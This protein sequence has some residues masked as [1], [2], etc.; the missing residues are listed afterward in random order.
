MKSVDSKISIVL[1]TYNGARYLRRSMES[2]LTQTYHN[3]ELIVVDDCSTDKT[4]E[5]VH[6]FEDRRIRYI[7]NVQNQRL[8]RSLNAGFQAATGDYLTWTSDDNFYMP[9]ALEKM[10]QC[11]QDKNGDFVYTDILAVLNDDIDEA[12]YEP[13]GDSNELDKHNCIRAC[14]LYTRKVLETVGPYDP[15]MELIEDY[16]YW[17][18]VSKHFPMLHIKEPLYYYRYHPQQ[19]YT[20]RWNEI[21]IIEFLFKVK[22]GFKSMDEVNWFMRDGVANRFVSR[23]VHKPRIKKILGRYKAGELSFTETRTMIHGL[24]NG[25]KS[26][27]RRLEG[28]VS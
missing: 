3:I 6:Q 19:L 4:A 25:G 2:C 8:P 24:L 10:I 21:R 18:R 1:P 13:L 9:M 15:D 22:N 11:L 26:T 28:A 20:A 16:D 17:V 5:V 7:R 23:F 12:A 14:F 27:G